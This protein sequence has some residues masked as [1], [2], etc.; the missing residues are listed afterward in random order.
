MARFVNVAAVRFETRAVRGE[1]D[2]REI[3]LRETADVLASLRGYGLN[4]V[5]FCEGVEALAQRPEA[6]E[7]AARPGEL[8]AL[9]R[10]FAA[11]ERCHVAGSVKLR[12]GDSI[13]NSLCF[14]GPDGRILGAYHKTYLT[15]GEIEEDGL[16]SGSGAVAVDT[17]IGRLGGIICFDLNFESL[18]RQYRALK[19]DILAFA[20]MYHGGLMQAVWA[21]E[22]R[23]YFVSALPMEG[24][25][26]L[27]PFGR[28]VKLTNCYT[29]VARATINLNRAMVHLDSNREKF[30]EIERKYLGEV[31]ID[32]PPNIGSALI[33]GLSDRVSAMD[34]VREF[35]LQLLDD[36]FSA[37]TQA[38][39]KN[40]AGR[41]KT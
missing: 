21:Y 13:Y 27:D 26:I 25:G 39:E 16:R 18:R 31:A 35:D 14:I 30:P 32:I 28:P 1:R 5:V 15:R 33:L 36:Y 8:L 7:E 40:R 41:K 29:P 23:S 10:E 9:Y 24:G 12:E 4:L 19:P 38:N 17:E 2:A 37:S 20:S 3:V 34:I 11:S 22:C 6:A